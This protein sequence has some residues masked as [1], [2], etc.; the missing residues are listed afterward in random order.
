[1]SEEDESLDEQDLEDIRMWEK[2]QQEIKE[3][4]EKLMNSH[5]QL[6]QLQSKH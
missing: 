3:H 2:K 4:I 1:V 6:E 5:K